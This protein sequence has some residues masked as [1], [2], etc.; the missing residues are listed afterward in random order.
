MNF[1]LYVRLT[2]IQNFSFDIKFLKK[3]M[4]KIIGIGLAIDETTSAFLL[5]SDILKK[6]TLSID[7]IDPLRYTQMPP[8]RPALLEFLLTE[9]TPSEDGTANSRRWIHI[10]MGSCR[11]THLLNRTLPLIAH[12]RRTLYAFFSERYVQHGHPDDAED[13]RGKGMSWRE[14]SRMIM[15]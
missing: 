12:K 2:Y 9:L 7:P 14:D 10:C 15:I 1:L 13:D 11:S 4:G 3:I 6:S 5:V 8:Q